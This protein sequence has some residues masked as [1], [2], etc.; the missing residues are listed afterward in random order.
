[1]SIK[2][3][4]YA[5]FKN[6]DSARINVVLPSGVRGMGP[7]AGFSIQVQNIMGV[8][9]DTFVKD[10]NVTVDDSII[11]LSTC[12]EDNKN[13]KAIHAKRIE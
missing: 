2:D 6:H 13:R 5:H 7:S 10:V 4:A 12:T 9:R 8:D 3:R 11:T 1:M